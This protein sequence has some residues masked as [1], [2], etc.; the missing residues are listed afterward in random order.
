[1]NQ[2]VE[3]ILKKLDEY[4]FELYNQYS[5][6]NNN[7]YFMIDDMVLCYDDND[8]ILSIAFKAS[9]I[10]EHV[11]NSL[12]ILKEIDGINDIEIMESFIYKGKEILSGEEAHNYIEKVHGNKEI[13]K[14]INKQNQIQILLHSK[15]YGNC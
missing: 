3:N 6:E 9:T 10:P 11:A 12:L 13:G 4:G 14:Y 8:K 15:I 1:M 2:G 7:H 5:D